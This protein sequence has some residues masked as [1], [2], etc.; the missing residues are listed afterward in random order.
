MYKVKNCLEYNYYAKNI[1]CGTV[2]PLSMIQ[3]YQSGD[4]YTDGKAL[5]FHHDCGFAILCGDIGDNFLCDV[6]YLIKN[7]KDDLWY[8]PKR[9]T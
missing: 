9:N 8:F 6:Y 5:L 4:I 3:G 2:Y 1:K 7:P